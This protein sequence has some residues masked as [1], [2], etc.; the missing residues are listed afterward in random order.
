M[1][2][3]SVLSGNRDCGLE[4]AKPV[5]RGLCPCFETLHMCGN[6]DMLVGQCVPSCNQLF[7]FPMGLAHLTLDIRLAATEAPGG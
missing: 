1:T 3:G 6:G 7:Q 5:F 2:K 4:G